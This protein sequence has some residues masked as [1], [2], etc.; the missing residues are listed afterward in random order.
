MSGGERAISGKRIPLYL[1]LLLF[2]LGFVYVAYIL[3]YGPVKILRYYILVYAAFGLACIDLQKQIIPN[4]ILLILLGIRGILFL[5]EM[6]L[7]PD[8]AGNF[9]W[10]A[11]SGA[12]FGMA[13]LF[14]GYFVCKKGMGMGDIKLFGV[15]GWYVGPTA[16][17]VMMFFSL[18]A[19]AV[20]SII[21]L[22]LKRIDKKDEIPFA[23]FCFAG[24]VIGALLG[25]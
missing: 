7:Y 22:I 14:A 4:K 24:V 10:S 11:V 20:Y 19:A 6:L 17:M 2:T 8:Y 16:V 5:P 18:C 25:V 9:I 15:I 3:E 12:L 13:V 1:L 21:L 23:P